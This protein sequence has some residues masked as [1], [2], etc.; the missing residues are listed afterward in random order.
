MELNAESWFIKKYLQCSPYSVP[1]TI[2]DLASQTLISTLIWG[3][4][5]M[6]ILVVVIPPLATAVNAVIA[7]VSGDWAGT[8]ADDSYAHAGV[9]L[10]YMYALLGTVMGSI[11][12]AKHIAEKR[13]QARWD[14][15]SAIERG[16]WVP[17]EP[18][19][20]VQIVKGLWARFK[21][22]TCVIITYKNLDE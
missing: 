8:F 1:R 21:D 6:L 22:K 16:D 20:F 15:A 3:I 18:S 14:R 12:L 13:R 2:C 11:H 5:V 19:K 9:R 7:L 17:K 4:A 10:T